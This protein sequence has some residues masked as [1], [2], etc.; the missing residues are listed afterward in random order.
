MANQVD[1]RDPTPNNFPQDY[2]PAKVDPRVK[3]RSESIKNKQKGVDTREAMYQALEIGSVT[4]NEAKTTA[5]NT[6]SRQDESEKKVQDTS[7]NV[8]NVLNGI[9]EKSGDSAAP[10]VMAA[11]K[12]EDKPAFN[13]LSERLKDMDKLGLTKMFFPKL[14]HQQ[15]D[16]ALLNLADKWILID[17]GDDRDWADL[18]TFITNH[19]NHI[20]IGIISHYHRDHFGNVV[21]IIQDED[22]KTT[23]MIWYAPPM[24][25]FTG[26]DIIANA[27]DD[28]K[29]AATADQS[30]VVVVDSDLKLVLDNLTSIQF[31][32]TSFESYQHYYDAKELSYNNYSMVALIKY[33]NTELFF[34]GDIQDGAI[35]W[36]MTHY[37]SY[38]HPFDFLKIPHHGTDRSNLATFYTIIRPEY[39][40]AM[41]S[42]N[43]YINASGVEAVALTMLS[44]LGTKTSYAFKTQSDYV[45]SRN[46]INPINNSRSLRGTSG[47]TKI[48][49][50]VKPSE[51]TP[52]DTDGSQ[53]NPFTTVQEALSYAQPIQ[54]VEY[55]YHLLAGS[56]SDITIM[57][58]PYSIQIYV[59]NGVILNTLEIRGCKS[60]NVWGDVHTVSTASR[61]VAIYDS[62]V[63]FHDSIINDDRTSDLSSESSSI[64][65]YA[66]ASNVSVTKIISNNRSA[67]VYSYSGSSVSVYG[68]EGKGNLFAYI[69]SLGTIYINNIGTLNSNT[70]EKESGGGRI[71]YDIDWVDVPTQ[72]GFSSN[73]LQIRAKGST[74]YI[75]GA[76]SNVNFPVNSGWITFAT[77]PGY[78]V[79]RDKY[80]YRFGGVASNGQGVPI[81]IEGAALK[82]NATSNK[83]DL[84]PVTY[85]YSLF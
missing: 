64:L 81:V 30:T 33:D 84:V 14:E 63:V 27:L 58:Q 26:M 41:A 80:T 5:I 20:D 45:I 65:L 53:K 60:V 38:L 34:V 70:Q 8:N 76:I 83:P 21:N 62:H 40:I 2:D 15:E 11:R 32:N 47:G 1:Y 72:N 55:I 35:N 36:V 74:V 48:E 44:A 57:S 85:S 79:P 29:A 23:G 9:T 78:F 4:A 13:T 77:L 51:I 25:I 24:P 71:N 10:E 43:N 50:Y 17:S 31:L 42:N 68:S 52:V 49:Y 37:A 54:G 18:K 28:L 46:G 6:A 73:G 69:A 3:L 75:R 12:P 22:I 56:Y 61:A 66:S 59:D 39:A 19:T 7:D 16:C 67:S 82:I